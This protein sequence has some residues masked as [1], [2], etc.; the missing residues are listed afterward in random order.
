MDCDPDQL[1]SVQS[2]S[3]IWLFATPWTTAPQ[4]SL[5]ITNSWSLPKPISIESVIPSNHLIL[6][7]LL[8]LP[9]SIFPSIIF[10]FLMRFFLMSWLFPSGGQRTWASASDLPKSIQG[11]LPVGLTGLNSLLSKGLSRV[12]S[13]TT[14][15][16]ITSSVLSLFYGP[17]LTSIH[18]YWK[19]HSFDYT[20]L[21]Q[22]SDVSAL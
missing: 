3:R 14:V 16:K 6:C 1:S 2:L 11:S 13:S 17:F 15:W 8:L 19:N 9:P 7:H 12:F 4:A 20:D 5:S 22:Q 18:N 10:C 21:C